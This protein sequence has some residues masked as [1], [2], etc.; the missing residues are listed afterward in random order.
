M[1]KLTQLKNRLNFIFILNFFSSYYYNLMI[2]NYKRQDLIV[3]NNFT[4]FTKK[5]Y[6]SVLL[7]AT[8]FLTDPLKSIFKYSRSLF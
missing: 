3:V 8:Y 4:L 2:A 7:L 6:I 5:L 1:N